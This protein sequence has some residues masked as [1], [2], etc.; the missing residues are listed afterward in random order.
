LKG[1]WSV[2][3]GSW[4]VDLLVCAGDFCVF[5]NL[6]FGKQCVCN[7]LAKII[8]NISVYKVPILVYKLPILVFKVPILV[9]KVP[10]FVFKVS[11]LV[12]GSWFVVRSLKSKVQSP[13]RNWNPE[14]T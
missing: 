8:V 3:S 11:I 7:K 6:D 13:K 9:Y 1:S 4:L 10:I 12:R 2:D 14:R 5:E